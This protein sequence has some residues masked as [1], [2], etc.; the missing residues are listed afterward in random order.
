[1][2]LSEAQQQYFLH[3]REVIPEKLQLFASHNIH[4]TW[5][6]VG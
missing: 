5:A 6:T 1:M 4:V 3:T 2:D